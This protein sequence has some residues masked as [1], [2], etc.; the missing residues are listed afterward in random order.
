MPSSQ[1]V[2]GDSWVSASFFR[3]NSYGN[4]YDFDFDGIRTKNPY[5]F[6]K[7]KLTEIFVFLTSKIIKKI[8]TYFSKTKHMQVYH[9]FTRKTI[10]CCL[11]ITVTLSLANIFFKIDQR[12]KF[13]M[14]RCQMFLW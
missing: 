13:F 8:R 12:T 2:Y 11:E 3:T 4:P 5:D 9:L 14:E 10:P 6:F 1:Q 7:E